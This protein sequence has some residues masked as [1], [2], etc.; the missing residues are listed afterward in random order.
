MRKM[1]LAFI[2]M[3]ILGSSSLSGAVIGVMS[4]AAASTG[5]SDPGNFQ[6]FDNPNDYTYNSQAEL[7]ITNE[8]FNGPGVTYT[9]VV[10]ESYSDIT[11]VPI[12]G[13]SVDD[14]VYKGYFDSTYAG[15]PARFFRYEH[16]GNMVGGFVS[17]YPLQY[18]NVADLNKHLRYP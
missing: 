16:Y 17:I 6:F 3:L 2:T 7:F 4:W 1:F 14:G 8:T 13:A 11:E 12:V 9:L 18:N 5:G 10:A 15:Y